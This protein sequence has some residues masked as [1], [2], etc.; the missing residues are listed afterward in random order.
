MTDSQNRFW[1]TFDKLFTL[2]VQDKILFLDSL[3]FS[4]TV[5]AR[6]IWSDEQP[7]DKDKA[8]AFKWLNEL[9]HRIWNI[10]FGLKE[11]I[12]IDSDSIVRLYENLKIYGEQSALLRIHLVP[13]LLSAFQLY[14]KY[15]QDDVMRLTAVLR[16]QGAA[17]KSSETGANCCQRG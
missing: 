13:T 6:G 12:D 14:K 4:F 3:L 16:Q 8:E 11:G 5:S 2:S 9:N 15:Q 1:E 17:N 10:R 7:S